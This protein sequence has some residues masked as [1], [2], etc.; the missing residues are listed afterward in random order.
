MHRALPFEP[1]VGKFL[2]SSIYSMDFTPST[3]R[4]TG[5][6]TGE[7][8]SD[9][10][11]KHRQHLS[12]SFGV[13]DPAILGYPE[14]PPVPLAGLDLLGQKQTEARRQAQTNVAGFP[15]ATAFNV[16]W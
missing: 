15:N 9:H 12:C 2:A 14:D 6:A 4:C 7:A 8:V 5:E 10:I 16:C 3:A 11:P 13:C 1:V